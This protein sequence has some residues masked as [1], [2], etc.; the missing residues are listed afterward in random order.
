MWSIS[1]AQ[2]PIDAFEMF[3]YVY[4][5]FEGFTTSWMV[6]YFEGQ[7]IFAFMPPLGRYLRIEEAHQNFEWFVIV[8][9]SLQFI[10]CSIIDISKLIYLDGR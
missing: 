8:P 4:I 3:V 9:N 10:W 5:S 2:N 1:F 6:E 7:C